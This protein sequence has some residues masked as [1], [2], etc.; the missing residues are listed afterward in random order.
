M[1]GRPEEE[2]RS[3]ENQGSSEKLSYQKRLDITRTLCL[4]SL[5]A[6]FLHGVRK[7]TAGRGRLTSLQL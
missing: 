7:V 4:S 2:K 1:G 6:N 5:Q 3:H